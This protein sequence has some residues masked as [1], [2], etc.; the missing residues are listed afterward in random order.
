MSIGTV[1]CDHT[2]RTSTTTMRRPAAPAPPQQRW[3]SDELDTKS[4][5]DPECDAGPILAT[6][7]VTGTVPLT[8]ASTVA[9]T[10]S[11][12]MRIVPLVV[13]LTVIFTVLF[14]TAHTC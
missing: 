11:A 2:L 8:E 1:I 5:R 6:L 4:D 7:V 14:F 12:S 10:I 9:L 13:F 3:R